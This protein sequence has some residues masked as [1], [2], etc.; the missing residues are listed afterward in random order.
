MVGKIRLPRKA[1]KGK[2]K[3]WKKGN[4]SSFNPKFRKFRDEAKGRSLYGYKG[5]GNLTKKALEKLDALNGE[6]IVESEDDA[7]SIGDKSLV[8]TFSDCSNPTFSRMLN[9]WHSNS[10]IQ[11]EMLA[12]LAAVTDT[13]KSK[14]GKETETEYFAA[15]MAILSAADTDES[16]SA[17]VSLLY[18]VIKKLPVGVRRLKFSGCCKVFVDLLSKYMNSDFNALLRN[19]LGCL[20]FFLKSQ[21]PG[22]WTDS[23]SKMYSVL[24]EFATHQK[25]KVRKTAQEAV[26]FNFVWS[27]PWTGKCY[28]M[29]SSCFIDSRVLHC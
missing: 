28:C 3:I 20:C 21:E 1:T 18:M 16:V 5:G 4:S 13:I 24:L 23:T 10:L 11:K 27:N 15:L 7:T 26:F 22:E 8:T 12:I 9:N 29:S 6:Q 2:G 17:V 14:G 25:P 19:L